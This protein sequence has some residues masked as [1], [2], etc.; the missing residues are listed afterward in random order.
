[1]E[2][3]HTQQQETSARQAKKGNG[4]KGLPKT[5]L[6]LGIIATAFTVICLMMFSC[7]SSSRPSTSAEIDE[8]MKFQEKW[9][10]A[11]KE[12]EQKWDSTLK[13]DD[14]PE[15]IGK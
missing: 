7:A 5:G 10:T 12:A 8:Q 9:I 2:N 1:M 15:S 6:R 11:Q 4:G 14:K 13:A 3:Q